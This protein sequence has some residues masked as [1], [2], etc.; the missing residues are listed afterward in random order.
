MVTLNLDA[1]DCKNLADMIEIYF[2]ANIRDDEDMDNI[3]YLRSML[4]GLDEL[5]SASKD[6]ENKS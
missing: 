4:R 1:D 6:A 3:D 5:R 2:F